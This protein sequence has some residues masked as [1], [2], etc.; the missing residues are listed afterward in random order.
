M[1]GKVMKSG[2]SFKGCVAYCM[3]KR[4]AK[5]LFAEGVRQTNAYQATADFNMQRKFNARLGQAV[6]HIALAFSPKDASILTN[7]RM[8]AIAQQYLERMKIDDTQLLVVKH[9]DTKH[10]HLHIIYNRV[11]N[12]GKTISDSL[13]REKNVRVAKAL[14]LEHGLYMSTGKQQVNRQRLKGAD[15][16]KYQIYDAV[17]SN[18]LK[19]RNMNELAQLLRKQG[20]VMDFKYRSGT[21]DIQGVSFIK[22]EYKFKGSE[23]DR[24]TSYAGLNRCIAERIVSEQQPQIKPSLAEQ[25]RAVI[26]ENKQSPSVVVGAKNTHRGPSAIETLL[27]QPAT[28]NQQ[29]PDDALIYRKRK[30]KGKSQGSCIS[31]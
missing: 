10:P 20:I 17:R 23:I 2:K 25:L 28:G 19:A 15:H 11:N 12:Q 13:L 4:D 21:K 1:M 7:E 6:G 24:S 26:K 8:V 9:T 22:G 3:N 31:R 14:T 27:K 18:I 29:T 16:V 30:K 5:V